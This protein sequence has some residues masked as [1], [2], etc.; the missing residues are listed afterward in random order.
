MIN[1]ITAVDNLQYNRNGVDGKSFYSCLVTV[2]EDR[3]INKNYLV[4]FE[5]DKSDMEVIKNNCRVINLDDVTST[6]RGDNFA[7]WLNEYFDK[8][9]EFAESI[10][11]L[12]IK[13]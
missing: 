7:I 9:L 2:K 4:T 5:T 11:N 8:Q 1:E 6:W 3:T 13:K 10:Y 12:S